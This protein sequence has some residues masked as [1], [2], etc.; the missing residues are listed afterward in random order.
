MATHYLKTW[1]VPFQAVKQ[2]LKTFEMRYND[3]SYQ[4]GDILVLQEY[5]PT[6]GS[7]TGMEVD[8]VVTYI[9]EGEHFG[10]Q[11]GFICMGIEPVKPAIA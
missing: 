1:T 11:E 5:K 8:R 10:L 2:L 3:R 6:T 7:F 4:V 9:Q